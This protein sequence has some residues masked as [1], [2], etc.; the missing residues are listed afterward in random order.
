MRFEADPVYAQK[1]DDFGSERNALQASGLVRAASPSGGEPGTP[2]DAGIPLI[3]SPLLAPTHQFARGSPAPAA[4]DGTGLAP[5]PGS[6][7]SEGIETFEQAVNR[8][9]KL[10]NLQHSK[11]QAVLKELLS[12]GKKEKLKC[13]FSE[14]FLVLKVKQ[15]IQLVELDEEED[16]EEL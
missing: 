14:D 4:M 3:Q 1:I 8:A 12:L 13:T 11:Q 10:R 5:T 2:L 7:A 15:A 16:E 9:L 6:A